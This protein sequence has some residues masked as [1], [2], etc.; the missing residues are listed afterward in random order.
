MQTLR[1]WAIIVVFLSVTLLCIPYQ[2]MA[3]RL[4]W[5]SRKTFPSSYHRFMATLFG[6]RIKTIGKPIV[7]RD[8]LAIEYPDNS[9]AQ[10]SVI[11]CSPNLLEIEIAGS[12]WRLA[13]L[14]P[15]ETVDVSTATDGMAS[16]VWV[17]QP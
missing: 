1:A 12:R 5:K 16:I 6:I 14:M 9:R 4:G 13:P 8:V 17:I 7:A 15:A 11:G 3:L 10:A 2:R